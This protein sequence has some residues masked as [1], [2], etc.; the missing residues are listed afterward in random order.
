MVNSIELNNFGIAFEDRSME[1]PVAIN[2][3][4]INFKLTNYSSEP[5]TNVPFKLSAGINKTGLINLTGDTFIQP[6]SARVAIDAKDIAMENFQ[7]YVNKFVQ[8]DI[9]DGKLAI[10]GNA[11]VAKPEKGELDV[12]F[13]GNTAI[14]SLLIRDQLLKENGQKKVLI[15]APAFALRGINFNLGNQELVMS[16][17]S[18]N[19][20]DLQAWLNPKGIINYQTLLRI[21]NAEQISIDET[22]ASTIKPQ[23]ATWKINVN[24]IALTN[25]GLNFED[26]TQ[27]KPVAMNFKPINFK[28]K[29][30]SNKSGVNLPVQLSV[31][32]NKTGVITLKG[33]TVIEP[34]SAKL[35]LDAKN[36]DL[37]KFQPY[38]DKFVRLDVM[39]GI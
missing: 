11:I 31:G 26:Q 16:S 1:N 4:P 21:S 10:D 25:F 14:T 22:I 18:A 37:E 23:S 36:I 32:M 38:F 30:Y 29:N 24:D 34:L 27:K 6:F 17:I 33:N 13:N 2:L 8:M 28:L 7:A 15:K 39:A 3:K 35:D 9:V 5:G 19:N 12:N 20:G